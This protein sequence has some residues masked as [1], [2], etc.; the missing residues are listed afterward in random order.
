MEPSEKTLR[1]DGYETEVDRRRGPARLGLGASF[2]YPAA[3][4]LFA[5][6]VGLTAMMAAVFADE[7]IGSTSVVVRTVTAEMDGDVRRLA[8]GENVRQNE[9]IET[10]DASA[11]EIVFLD[12]TKVAVGPNTRLTLDSFVFDPDPARGRFEVTTDKGVFRFDSGNLANESYVIRTPTVTIGVGGTARSGAG[13]AVMVVDCM[14][15]TTVFSDGTMLPPGPPPEWAVASMQELDDVLE[16]AET[17][18]GY[19]RRESG[20]YTG[21]CR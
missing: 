7:G 6:A 18:T 20:R 3:A 4:F 16:E 12:H 17:E 10:A 1:C 2:R 15:S 21:R 13:N 11:S 8:P 19:G 9:L 14:L 5:A